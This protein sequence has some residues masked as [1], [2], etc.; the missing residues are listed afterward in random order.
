MRK[1]GLGAGAP[2]AEFAVLM[3]CMGNIC[4]SPTAE[5]VLRQKLAAA[6]LGDRVR[7]DSAGT[8]SYHVGSPPDDRAQAAARR[9][10]FDLGGL[11][12]RRVSTQDFEAFDLVLAMDE[13]NF[14]ELQNMAPAGMESRVKLLMDFARVRKDV[15]EVPDPY[16]GSP[17]GFE[18]MLD[19]VIDASDGLVTVLTRMLGPAP[20]R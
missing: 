2:E 3:V 1:L 11:R 12:A 18:L 19:L 5:A 8:H 4:R 17:A 15:R 14:S 9:R 6:G 7:V 10:G 20:T 16:Y 13:D